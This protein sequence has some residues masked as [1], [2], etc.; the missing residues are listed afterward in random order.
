MRRA[1]ARSQ[2]LDHEVDSA[3]YSPQDDL[4]FVLDGTEVQQLRWNR[5]GSPQVE[6]VL[7][8]SEAL[9]YS[10][11][12][13]GLTLLPLDDGKL[14][15]A[16]LTDIGSRC[17]ETRTSSR[18]RCRLKSSVMVWWSDRRALI[19]A[20]PEAGSQPLRQKTMDSSS[21]VPSFKAPAGL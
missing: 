1:S 16:L 8:G 18:C 13:Y 3:E 11:Q 14:V 9:K 15:P 21:V 5:T 19:Q 6:G 10:R 20:P 17:T 2:L 7:S 12:I 4:F